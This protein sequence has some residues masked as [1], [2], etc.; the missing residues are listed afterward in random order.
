MVKNIFIGKLENILKINQTK[1]ALINMLFDMRK[2]FKTLH[3]YNFVYVKK[4]LIF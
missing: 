3:V 1:S 2:Y 4:A